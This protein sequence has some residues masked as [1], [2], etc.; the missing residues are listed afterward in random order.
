ML[1]LVFILSCFCISLAAVEVPDEMPS[2]AKRLIKGFEDDAA[3]ER[4]KVEREINKMRGELIKD[5]EKELKSATKRENLDEALLVKAAIEEL[6]E[7]RR[8]NMVDLMSGRSSSKPRFRFVKEK[9]M[10]LFPIG[11]THGPFPAM[12]VGDPIAVFEG[13]GIFFDQRTDVDDLIYEVQ[14]PRSARKLVYE[15]GA[16]QNL[17]IKITDPKGNV[18]G[19]GGPWGGGNQ[20]LKFEVPMKA[21]RQ[22]VITIHNDISTWFYISKLS[23]E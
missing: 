3:K 19:E 6:E 13:K 12:E 8:E 21:S 11:T 5:L 15:G 16:A 23:F 9:S 22:F 17:T 20:P 4:A 2:K 10:P 7:E 14:L 1:R 18:L